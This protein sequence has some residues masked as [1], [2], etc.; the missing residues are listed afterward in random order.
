MFQ[1]Q[2][3]KYAIA[4][5]C[6]PSIYTIYRIIPSTKSLSWRHI[7]FR[8]NLSFKQSKSSFKKR[9]RLDFLVFNFWY[10]FLYY[11]LPFCRYLSKRQT[12]KTDKKAD[13]YR[14]KF[15]RYLFAFLS[16]FV[17]LFVGFCRL[18]SVFVG[19]CRFLS[20]ISTT[21]IFQCLC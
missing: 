14:Q 19:F 3:C 10:G 15:C 7:D 20:V 18:L 13:K 16:V 6:N 8:N 21:P 11:C 9:L 5:T 4:Y 2:S 1:E 17:C 12:T